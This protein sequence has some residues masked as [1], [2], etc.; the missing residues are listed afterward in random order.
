L[1][2][3]RAQIAAHGGQPLPAEHDQHIVSQAAKNAATM[4][5]L[6]SGTVQ[7]GAQVCR[8][9][10][11]SRTTTK[12]KLHA[13]STLME[14]RLF[15]SGS[16]SA[17]RC[18][19]GNRKTE[20]T[21][22]ILPGRTWRPGKLERSAK[23]ARYAAGE[24]QPQLKRLITPA[25]ASC[26]TRYSRRG[27]GIQAPGLRPTGGWRQPGARQETEPCIAAV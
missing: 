19:R 26:G 9:V 21:R 16:G 13:V 2:L 8:S 20:R 10:V 12:T 24:Q 27:G 4:R 6:E 7:A 5:P 22:A 18:A 11:P 25:S 14:L 23:R 15:A 17:L 1:K 3:L